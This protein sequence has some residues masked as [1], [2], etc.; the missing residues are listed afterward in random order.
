MGPAV[1]AQ[2][3]Q[4]ASGPPSPPP[5]SLCSLVRGG[6]P[7]EL[8]LTSHVDSHGSDWQLWYLGTVPTVVTLPGSITQ[9][10]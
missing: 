8:G 4:L 1:T 5:P 3:P 9:S 6:G 7:S 2:C 10:K